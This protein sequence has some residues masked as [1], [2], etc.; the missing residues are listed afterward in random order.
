M[1]W[2][3]VFTVEQLFQQQTLT[4]YTEGALPQIIYPHSRQ[5]F[6]L[7]HYLNNH[8]PLTCLFF[9]NIIFF[10]IYFLF[11]FMHICLL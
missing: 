8:F 9:V 11:N 1:F 5:T 3:S 10:S 4:P 2:S 7:K 6:L